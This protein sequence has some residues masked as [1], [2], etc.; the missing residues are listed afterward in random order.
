MGTFIPSYL[1]RSA[2]H[3]SSGPCTLSEF[4][5]YTSSELAHCEKGKTNPTDDDLYHIFMCVYIYMYRYMY[6]ILFYPDVN[7]KHQAWG[8]PPNVLRELV[9][10]HPGFG[11]SFFCVL[12]TMSIQS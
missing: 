9:F 11:F 10:L 4:V 8:E 6:Y 5:V 1:D 7:F 3:I 2:T 12:F